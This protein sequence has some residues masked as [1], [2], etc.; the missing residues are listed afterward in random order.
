MHTYCRMMRGA[1]YVKNIKDSYVAFGTWVFKR[2][3]AHFRVPH[4]KVP[5]LTETSYIKYT[6]IYSVLNSHYSIFSRNL[7]F[8]TFFFQ[9]NSSWKYTLT[10]KFCT[11]A[12]I[13]ISYC[14]ITLEERA[15]KVARKLIQHKSK[16]HPCRKRQ[17]NHQNILSVSCTFSSRKRLWTCRQTDY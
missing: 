2:R 5:T 6:K 7:R 16:M 17:N 10:V 3:S 1:S 11:S 8:F 15:L 4:N 13:H 9:I 14:K 12:K